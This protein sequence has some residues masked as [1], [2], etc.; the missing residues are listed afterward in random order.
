MQ[1]GDNTKR[2]NYTNQER[3]KKNENMI[4]RKVKTCLEEVCLEVDQL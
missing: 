4:S 2:V 3:G 1:H